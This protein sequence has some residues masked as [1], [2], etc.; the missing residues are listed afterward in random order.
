MSDLGAAKRARQIFLQPLLKAS[1]VKVMTFV[2]WERRHVIFVFE[3]YEA[4]NALVLRFELGRHKRA[5]EQVPQ[6]FLR[7]RRSFG[8]RLVLSVSFEAWAAFI[9]YDYEGKER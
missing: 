9:D 3:L 5:F 4:D 1:G 7:P 6:R 2:A 8:S